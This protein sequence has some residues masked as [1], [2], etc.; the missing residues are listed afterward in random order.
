MAAVKFLVALHPPKIRFFQSLNAIMGKIGDSQAVSLVLSLAATN[1]VPILLYGMEA[2]SVTNAQIHSLEHAYNAI[3]FKVFRS[4]DAQVIMHCQF[5]TGFL[6][7][8]K[9]LDLLTLRFLNTLQ[10]DKN[11][12]TGFLSRTVGAEEVRTLRDKYNIGAIIS[13]A[14]TK[15]RI[16]EVFTDELGLL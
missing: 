3:F 15:K 4:F 10:A 13:H 9:A 1:C 6:P 8:R 11:S 14:G 16:W 12:L 5:Y 7:L 2:C